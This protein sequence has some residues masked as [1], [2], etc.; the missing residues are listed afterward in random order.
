MEGEAVRLHESWKMSRISKTANGKT[1][2]LC[3]SNSV[4][5]NLELVESGN[6]RWFSVTETQGDLQM[7]DDRGS[8]SKSLV[9]MKILV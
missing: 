5:N 3:R 1:S 8:L 2:F 7:Q 6:H 4:F 9:T